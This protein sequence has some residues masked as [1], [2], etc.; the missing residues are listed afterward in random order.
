MDTWLTHVIAEIERNGDGS[1]LTA[2]RKPCMK[3]ILLCILE[4][5]QIGGP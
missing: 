5:F 2:F 3:N 4:R 1:V